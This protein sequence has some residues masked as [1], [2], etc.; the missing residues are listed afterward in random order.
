MNE[1]RKKGK[2]NKEKKSESEWNREEQR[3]KGGTPAPRGVNKRTV[4][5]VNM[6]HHARFHINRSNHC[7]DMTVCR[8]FKMAP[9]CHVGF[10]KFRNCNCRTLRSVNVRCHAK[11]RADRS[12]CCRDMAV[13]S[14]FK[15]PAVRHHGSL[16]V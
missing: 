15:M 4:R 6:T 9:V 2:G 3:R 8:F 10:L 1:K 7:R 16:K 11:F 13:Y 12:S 5:R 14:I